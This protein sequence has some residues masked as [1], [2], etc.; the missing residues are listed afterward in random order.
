MI[1]FDEMVVTNIRQ[2]TV[3]YTKKGTFF[4][5]ESRQS[6]GLSFCLG[7]QITYTMNG[8]KYISDPDHAILT[9][10]GSATTG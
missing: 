3:V 5:M 4:T 7:G 8:K 1:S 9:P 2:P 6:F 10:Q